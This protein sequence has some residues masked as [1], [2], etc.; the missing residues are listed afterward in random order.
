M[1]FGAD[2]S[3]SVHADNEEN[4]WQKT[5]AREKQSYF[6]CGKKCLI[7][8]TEEHNKFFLSLRYDR[9]N[10]YLLIMLKYTSLKQQI[11][12]KCTFDLDVNL[13]H[14]ILRVFYVL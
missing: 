11:V 4:I 10:I 12:K 6:H 3:S 5:N 13:F 7:Q 8:F 1:I 9:G 14:N 2:M